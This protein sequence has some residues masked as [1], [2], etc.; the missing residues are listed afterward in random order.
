MK[1]NLSLIIPVFNEA[2]NIEPLVKKILLSC[3]SLQLNNYEILFIDDGSTDKTYQNIF[4]LSQTNKLIKIIKFRRNFGKATAYSV[5]FSHAKYD[6]IITLDGDLQDDPLEIKQFLQKINEG[7][8]LVVGWKKTGKGG[9]GKTI[10]SRLFNQVTGWVF[11][12]RLHDIDCP[13]KAYKGELIQKLKIY[14]GLYRFIPIFAQ[15]FGFKVAEVEI[16]NLPRLSGNSKFGSKRLI[17][18]FFDFLTVIFITKF[19]LNPMHFFGSLALFSI[20]IGSSILVYLTALHF[21]GQSVGT[22][23]LFQLGILFEIMGLQF[24][25]IGFIGEM[26]TRSLTKVDQEAIIEKPSNKL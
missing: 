9:I 8:D 23:P 3:R 11:Q 6:T 7:Y 26:L 2:E 12:T 22:R 15:S 19:S 17:T 18:G 16:N 25:S 4:K 20:L 14:S 10:F 24:F 21:Q 1:Q 5:G 13:F